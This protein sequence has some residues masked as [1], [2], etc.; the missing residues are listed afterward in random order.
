MSASG[1]RNRCRTADLTSDPDASPESEEYE[2]D[3]TPFTYYNKW[4]MSS[5]WIIPSAVRTG[6][7]V[8]AQKYVLF[9]FDRWPRRW[10]I[11]KCILASNTGEYERMM[12]IIV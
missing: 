9:L 6:S 11:H 7:L 5:V 12:T 8:A 4:E 2:H 3:Y 1:N 10:L